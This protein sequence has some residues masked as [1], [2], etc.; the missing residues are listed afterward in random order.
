VSGVRRGVLR[1]RMVVPELR[2]G[3]LTPGSLVGVDLAGVLQAAGVLESPPIL[4]G[5]EVVYPLAIPDGVEVAIPVSSGQGGGLSALLGRME[6]VLG[7]DGGRLRLLVPNAPFIV[8]MVQTALKGWITAGPSYT[9][10]GVVF[11]LR[12]RPGATA[13]IPLGPVGRWG[14]EVPR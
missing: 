13:G 1:L 9:S 2:A 6:V 11:W 4:R 14:V 5:R 3:S 12:L 8:P 7:N 10:A